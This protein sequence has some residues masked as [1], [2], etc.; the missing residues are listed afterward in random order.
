MFTAFS[1]DSSFFDDLS[2]LNIS[3]SGNLFLNASI[4]VSGL[5]KTLINASDYGNNTGLDFFFVIN[6]FSLDAAAGSRDIDLPLGLGDV[7]LGLNNAS[8]QVEVM[9]SLDKPTNITDLFGENATSELSFTG[10]LDIALPVEVSVDGSTFTVIVSVNDTNIFTGD[11]PSIAYAYDLCEIKSQIESLFHN[12]SVTVTH[13]L[14]ENLQLDGL[15][16]QIDELANP[17]IEKAQQV[18]YSFRKLLIRVQWL[19]LIVCCHFSLSL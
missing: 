12:L 13:A 10:S 3:I 9:I 8:F 6:S 19:F 14:E 5:T 2:A 7:T 4:G 17:I 1:V 16:I 18:R 15:P 11:G